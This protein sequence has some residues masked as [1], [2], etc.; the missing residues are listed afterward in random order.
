MFY[1]A[2]SVRSK[3]Q[4][5]YIRVTQPNTGLPI[6]IGN[7]QKMPIGSSL[8]EE[9]ATTKAVDIGLSV[10]EIF[11]IAYNRT[12]FRHCAVTFFSSLK[13]ICIRKITSKCPKVSVFH[14]H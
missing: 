7:S 5:I 9:T 6:G 11:Q 12:I 10:L 1:S 13:S 8:C 14:I 2:I 3:K 4:L